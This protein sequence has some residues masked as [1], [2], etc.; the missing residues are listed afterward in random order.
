MLS[1]ALPVVHA[2]IPYYP[3]ECP[4]G[5][6]GTDFNGNGHEGSQGLPSWDPRNGLWFSSNQG[7]D[8]VWGTWGDIPTPGDFNGDGDDDFAVFRPST[9]TW[10]VTCMGRIARRHA[11][12]S[13]G[14]GWRYP[15]PGR[16]QQ[17][18]NHRLWRV[19]TE[20]RLLVRS[21]RGERRD[22]GQRRGL[23]SVRGLSDCGP[24]LG[25]GAGPMQLNVWRP[26]NGVWYVGRDVCGRRAE[27][28]SRLA[29]TA[30]YPSRRTWT[31]TSTATW[32]FFVRQPA[33]GTAAIRISPLPGDS[34]AISRSPVRS[35]RSLRQTS[36]LTVYR[37]TTGLTYNCFTPSGS[38]C[39]RDEHRGS[40]RLAW[41]RSPSGRM[42]VA[43]CVVRVLG[44][45]AWGHHGASSPVLMAQRVPGLPF[46]GFPG[47]LFRG[48]PGLPWRVFPGLPFRVFPGS[49]WLAFPSSAS[50]R[51][52]TAAP[53]SGDA[54]AGV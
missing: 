38:S 5:S 40:V 27:L 18:R 21:Q 28:H 48:F 19:A 14:H 20:Q 42:E 51:W 16:L 45:A 33:R 24:T 26:S 50:E 47:L 46:R 22:A 54:V 13:M 1:D 2:T 12:G 35:G 7:T 30:I 25:C 43:R 36:A 17:R 29:P 53:D 41:R 10:F 9:G 44:P 23:G 39:T 15:R 3:Y 32:S 4:I 49:P 31:V 8:P 52:A 11:V 34:R 6:G 37:P